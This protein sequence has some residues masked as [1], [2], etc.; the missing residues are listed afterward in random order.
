MVAFKKTKGLL[1]QIEEK[2][3]SDPDYLIT[4]A[5]SPDVQVRPHDLAAHHMPAFNPQKPMI[6]IPASC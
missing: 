1:L 5:L 4:L 2:Q 3:K 6:V